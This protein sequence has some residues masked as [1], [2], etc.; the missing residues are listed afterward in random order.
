MVWQRKARAQRGLSKNLKHTS[1]LL[2]LSGHVSNYWHESLSRR[3]GC[4]KAKKVLQV[5]AIG[6]LLFTTVFGGSVFAETQKERAVKTSSYSANFEPTSLPNITVDGNLSDWAG[7]YPIINGSSA[8]FGFRFVDCY[9]LVEEGSL[10]FVFLKQ[11]GGSSWYSMYFD[12]DLSNRSG[13]GINGIEAKYKFDLDA[14]SRWSG[15]GWQDINL[16]LETNLAYLHGGA[17]TPDNSIIFAYGSGSSG[18]SP[19]WYEGKISLSWLGNPTTFGLVFEEFPEQLVAPDTGYT[20]VSASQYHSFAASFTS[21]ATTLRYG[22]PLDMVFNLLNFGPDSLDNVDVETALPGDFNLTTGPLSFRSTIQAGERLTQ[23]IVA[24]PLDYGTATCYSN[25]TWLDNSSGENVAFVIPLSTLTLPNIAL[26]LEAPDNMVVGI[27]SSFNV[28]VVNDDPLWAPVTIELSPYATG[29]YL[30]DNVPLVLSPYSTVKL[31]DLKVVPTRVS[32]PPFEVSASYNLT[33]VD[34]KAA[35]VQVRL[36]EIHFVSINVTSEMQAGES[37]SVA[38]VIENQENFSYSVTT[39]MVLGPSLSI[40]VQNVSST[41]PPISNSTVVF[42]INPEGDY[43]YGR[44]YLTSAYGEFG[45][46]YFNIE[47]KPAPFPML[48]VY[49][50]VAVAAFVVALIVILK[51]GAIS[52]RLGKRKPRFSEKPKAVE[53]AIRSEEE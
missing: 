43:M 30:L 25:F 44:V 12:T 29:D 34:D 10:Y 5:I 48:I 52:E 21:T 39:S 20:V 41:L 40:A 18:D 16:S 15:S 22:Q 26:D 8:K 17:K 37:Y 6:L 9:V 4:V 2:N 24:A 7:I 23:N 35:Q 19:E 31:L 36:P 32:A 1:L 42:Q 47:V 27:D 45:E 11:P 51:R 46:E 13:Y 53:S 50:A 49:S 38:A 33:S 14:L 28:T 3:W